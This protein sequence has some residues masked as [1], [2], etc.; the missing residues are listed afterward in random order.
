MNEETSLM[1]KPKKIWNDALKMVKGEDSTQ[2]IEQFTAEMTLV[3]EGLC[4]DQNQLRGEVNRLM[5]EEERRL[6]KQGAQVDHLETLLEEQQ[7]ENDR[8]ITELR[9]RLSVLE[10]QKNTDERSSEKKQK[11][12]E[13]NRI[14][15]LT[16]LIIVTAAAVIAVVLV[17]KLV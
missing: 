16:W 7:R 13:R 5:N 4:E 2:L 1:T 10:K 11:N 17:V 6:Q 9:N 8:V 3:A 12:K 15:D 14:R